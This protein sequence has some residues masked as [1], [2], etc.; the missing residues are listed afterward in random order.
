MGRHAAA[1]RRLTSFIAVFVAVGALAAPSAAAA[2]K[3]VT[4]NKATTKPDNPGNG[5]GNGNGK[6]SPTPSPTPTATPSPTPTQTTPPPST[7]SA[8]T[9]VVYDGSGE[10]G[11]LGE[12]YATMIANL[13]G[14]FGTYTATPVNKYTAG[15][16]ANYTGVVYI[17]S[18]WDEALPVAFLD[19]VLSGKTPVMWVNRN[20][21]ALTSRATPAAFKEKYGWMWWQMDQADVR[22]IRYK[23]Q[24][25]LRDPNNPKGIMDYEYLDQS[26]VKVL[27]EAVRPDGTSFPWAV[28]SGNLT[29]VGE[30]PLSY[31]NEN[32]RYMIFSD[33][34]FDLLAP[35]TPERHRAMIRLEDV[36]PDADPQELR[37]A[38]DYLSRAGV[39]F[40]FGVYTVWKDPNNIL[41]LGIDTLRMRDVPQVVDA[42]KY[43]ISKG[44]TMLMHGYTHQYESAMNPYSGLSGDDFEFFTAHVDAENYVRLDG[45]V[46]NDS[47]SYVQDRVRLATREFQASKLPVPTIWE[48]PHYA[49]SALDYKT[50]AGLFTTRYERSLYF[51]GV[52]SGTT[53]STDVNRMVGQ[54]FP[55]VVNDVYGSKVLPENLGNYEPVM[56]NNH[57]PRSPEQ[58]IES[59]KRNLVVRDGFAS[60]FYHPYYGVENLR[61]TVEGIKALGY[62][63][64]S[65][66][67]L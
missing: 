39:P 34:L 25:I 3:K 8:R 18:T 41:G 43:M 53:P 11:H 67:S 38:A 61:A 56:V 58:M 20:I 19:D 17:G 33:L 14:H 60:F 51:A 47:A 52:L 29:Y 5:N 26:R 6:P 30:N 2:G 46:P 28:R 1:L 44:G 15:Q 48:F 12:L 65:P 40:S 13:A 55:Y 66:T 62:T 9:L 45:P 22:Q 7:G 37:A 23:G 57:P 31:I 4:T 27:A 35:S 49:G 50:I 63:F 32:D 54:F 64:V 24:T 21:W 36:G 59:A 10:W 16:M 42:I